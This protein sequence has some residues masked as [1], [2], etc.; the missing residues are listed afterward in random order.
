M[1]SASRAVPAP[2]RHFSDSISAFYGEDTVK[3]T[4]KLTLSL[5]LRYEIPVYAQEEDGIISFLNLNTPNPGAAGRPGARKYRRTRRAMPRSAIIP[6]ARP[7]PVAA[8]APTGPTASISGTA[9]ASAY[10]MAPNCWPRATPSRCRPSA[11]AAAT[12]YSFTP[13]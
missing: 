4:K 13:K 8:S 5:G 3:L 7:T 1:F 9:K 12:R 10:R 2:L 11:Q 6:S